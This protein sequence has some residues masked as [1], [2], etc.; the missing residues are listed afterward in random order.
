M[1]ALM[2]KATLAEVFRGKPVGKEEVM[3]VGFVE[4]AEFKIFFLNIY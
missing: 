1:A 2:E 3:E 4:G